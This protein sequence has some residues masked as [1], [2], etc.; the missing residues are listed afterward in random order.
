[1]RFGWLPS[2][3]AELTPSQLVLLKRARE[4]YE[5]LAISAVRDAI[6]NALANAYQKKSSNPIPLPLFDEIDYD[7]PVRTMSAGEA[8]QKMAALEKIEG[9]RNFLERG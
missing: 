9:R 8:M 3:F 6:G 2:Q 1:M 7:K 5:V 4:D